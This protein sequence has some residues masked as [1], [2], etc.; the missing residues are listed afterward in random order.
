MLAGRLATISADT[1]RQR[2]DRPSG[3][4]R[5]EL[6]PAPPVRRS[7]R[8]STNQTTAATPSTTNASAAMVQFDN[9]RGVG[10][11]GPVA[12][13]GHTWII[14][15]GPAVITVFGMPSSSPDD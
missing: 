11:V 10:W 7:G 3:A 6:G 5:L 1:R 13:C 15:R 14:A 12:R 8:S 2:I 4:D 9:G